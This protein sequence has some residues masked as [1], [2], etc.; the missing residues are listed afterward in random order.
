MCTTEQ[1]LYD[2]IKEREDNNTSSTLF[3]KKV[4]FEVIINNYSKKEDPGRTNLKRFNNTIHDDKNV[5]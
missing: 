3:K 4:D 2:F 5:K 1:R